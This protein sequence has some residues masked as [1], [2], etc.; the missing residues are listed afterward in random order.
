[1]RQFTTIKEIKTYLRERQ[2]GGERTGFVPTMGYL[3]EGH[4]SLI[5]R[6]VAENDLAVV[7]IFVNPLQFGPTEDLD[8]YPR[9][10]ERDLE[11]IQETGAAAVF[12]P[13]AAEMYR[14]DF[15]TRV[16]VEEITVILCGAS[17][18]G[19]FEGVTTVVHKLFQIVRPD[20]AYFGQKDGQQALVIQ[21][22]VRDLDMDVAIVVCPTV[23]EADGLA[24]SSRNTYLNPAERSQA[25]V[26]YQ[27]LT[28]AK[29]LIESGET[30]TGLIKEQMTTLI[31]SKPLAN[32]DYIAFVDTAS[33]REISRI[34]GPVMAALAVKFGTTRLIDNI[35]A[36]G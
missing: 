3:H 18:P 28:A 19:H 27:A 9:D 4:L 13:D 29:K 7:S 23:R 24:M 10:L 25:A 21:K 8:K 12:T 34:S 30:D 32:L 22:M 1:M 35:V 20:K 14:D 2:S 11:L 6:A 36:E 15:L 26:L 16:R 31:H 33:C 17:R 5:R